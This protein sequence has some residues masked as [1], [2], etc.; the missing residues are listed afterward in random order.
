MENHPIPQDV[1]GFQFKLIGSMTIKQFAYVAAGT[2]VAVFVYYVP[3]PFLI[4]LLVIPIAGGLGAALAFLPI[5]G[6]PFDVMMSNFFKDLFSPTQYIYHKT[7]GTLLLSTI[8]LTHLQQEVMQMKTNPHRD[9]KQARERA[10]KLSQLLQSVGSSSKTQLD[11][12]EELF[13]KAVF[14]GPAPATFSTSQTDELHINQH[15]LSVEEM[16]RAKIAPDLAREETA[17]EK[18]AEAIKRE[19]EMAKKEEAVLEQNHQETS[20]A[21]TEVITLEQQLQDIVEQKQKLEQ[22]LLDLKQKME[23]PAATI[24][25]EEPQKPAG[26]AVN[27]HSIPMDQAKK[28]GLPTITDHPN[29]VMGILRDSRGNVLPNIL[30]EIKDTQGNPVRAFKTNGLGQ[31]AS[32]TALANGTYTIEFEDPKLK[33]RFEV[34]QIKA[35]GEIMLP[36]EVISIDDR[37]VLRRELFAQ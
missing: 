1:T 11:E 7:G 5:E 30:V 10:V 6:R 9:E 2:V 14:G 28:I 13:L 23:N 24:K 33:H 25:K 3:F 21:H 8:D 32:A 20:S 26:Q 36:L 4:K 31:F 18:E 35:N 17:L 12:K 37:E 27:V 34:V 19:L 16:E 29:V 22:E 15:Q